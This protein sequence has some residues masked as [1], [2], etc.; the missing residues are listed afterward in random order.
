[1]S[2]VVII[3]SFINFTLM[4]VIICNL[5]LML[6]LDLSSS[7]PIHGLINHGEYS[8][9]EL[10]LSVRLRFTIDT[11]KCCQHPALSQAAPPPVLTHSRAGRPSAPMVDAAIPKSSSRPAAATVLHA[12]VRILVGGDSAL[13]WCIV[14]RTGPVIEPVKVSVH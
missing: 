14:I 4:S 5:C 12:R 8:K 11:S 7:L 10:K 2:W 13:G 3:H 6:G 1:M 9:E